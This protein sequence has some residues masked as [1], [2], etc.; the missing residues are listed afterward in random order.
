MIIKCITYITDSIILKDCDKNNN[1]VL[2]VML[3][4]L[5]MKS[6][7]FNLVLYQ[8]KCNNV[9]TGRAS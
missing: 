8:E 6:Y 3:V 5:C 4:P 1:L 9:L 7:D 2:M